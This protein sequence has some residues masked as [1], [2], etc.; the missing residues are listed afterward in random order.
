M[1][2]TKFKNENE[3]RAITPK[4]WRFGYGSCALHF[5]SMR[6]IIK[7]HV[8]AL[9]SF[10]VMLQTKKGRTDGRTSQ[11]LYA[12]L[13]GHKKLS[14]AHTVDFN[15]T[16][17]TL[18]QCHNITPY[19]TLIKKNNNNKKRNPY[20]PYL[21]FCGMSQAYFFYLALPKNIIK[22]IRSIASL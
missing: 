4:V 16:N 22:A 10:K 19:S 13:R 17:Y 5:S 20:L 1:L 3:Q 11:L 14:V 12:T 2:R 21:Y 7:F 9:H 15:H 8:D 18:K 6:S